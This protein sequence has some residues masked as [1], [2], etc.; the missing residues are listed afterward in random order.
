MKLVTKVVDN[1]QLEITNV[2]IRIE[3]NITDPEVNIIFIPIIIKIETICGGNHH[4]ESIWTI[5]RS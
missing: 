3:D 2:H 1:L 5:Y 4:R